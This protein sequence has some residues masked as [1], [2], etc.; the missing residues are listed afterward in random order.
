MTRWFSA[1]WCG[2]VLL[3]G[4]NKGGDTG[5]ADVP[6]A[7]N[8]AAPAPAAAKPSG[9]AEAKEKLKLALDSWVF[10]DTLEKF[11]KDH[12][13]IRVGVRLHS[14]DKLTRYDIGTG[15]ERSPTSYEF[16][17]THVFESR[18]GTDIKRSGTVTVAKL[19]DK[20]FVQGLGG[21]N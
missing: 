13:D 1:V 8:P 2:A 10:G 15:R 3:A 14:L 19:S 21:D 16:T 17:V 12:P 6:T 5:K 9:E 20:W 18:A 11:H 4:C 7:S